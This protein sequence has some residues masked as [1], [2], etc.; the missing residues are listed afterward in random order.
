MGGSAR[1]G[2]S[3]CD[4]SQSSS[5]DQSLVDSRLVRACAGDNAAFQNLAE[6]AARA[7]VRPLD[8]GL[9]TLARLTKEAA[10][11]Q[12]AAAQRATAAAARVVIES[13]EAERELAAACHA[14][15]AECDR[16]MAALALLIRPGWDEAAWSHYDPAD[17][18]KITELPDALCLGG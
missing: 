16:A 18:Q 3:D 10:D 1:S 5:F 14:A 2:I 4:V 15:K 7:N 9:A 12:T 8:A 17:Q 13:T 6:A 11:R